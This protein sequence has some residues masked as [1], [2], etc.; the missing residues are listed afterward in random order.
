[1]NGQRV[2]AV[3]EFIGE[4]LVDHAMACKA[5]LSCKSFR[6]DM[7]PEMGLSARTVGC[8]AFME[9]GFVDHFE[10]AGREGICQFFDNTVSCCH[11]VQISARWLIEKISAASSNRVCQVLRTDMHRLHNDRS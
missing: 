4:R 9:M 6:H 10:P 7:D 8:V 5:A 1:M 11:S 3:R 2:D